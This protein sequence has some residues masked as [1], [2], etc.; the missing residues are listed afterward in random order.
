MMRR[1]GGR[2]I[3]I[4]GMAAR[5]VGHLTTSNGV[6]NA[7]VA[8]I[9]KNFA[10]QVAQD[11]VLVNCIHPGTTRTPRQTMLLERRARDLGG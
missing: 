6:T 5:Q 3:N 10:D 11:N 4:G 7:S 2:I 9:A 8:N 1:G